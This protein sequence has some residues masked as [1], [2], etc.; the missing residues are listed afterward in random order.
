[1]FD[2]WREWISF[3]WHYR[4]QP[5]QLLDA[6]F[7]HIALLLEAVTNGATPFAKPFLHQL[8]AL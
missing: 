7:E 3:I 6:R 1:M 5:F 4:Q 8:H 2:V